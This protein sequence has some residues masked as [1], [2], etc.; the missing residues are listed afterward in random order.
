M[1]RS[2]AIGPDL[3]EEHR[4]RLLRRV[5][6]RFLLPTSRP[7][8][9]LCFAGGEL[10]AA[11]SLVSEVVFAPSAPLAGVCDLAVA[12]NPTPA[13]LRQAWSALVPGGALYTEWYPRGS[14]HPFAIGRRLQAAGFR[15]VTCYVP[16]RLPPR[17]DLWLPLGAP[18]ALRFFLRR[19]LPVRRLLRRL[20]S[21]AFRGVMVGGLRI[22]A[23]RP[24]C[25]VAVRPGGPHERVLP[26]ATDPWFFRTLD[27]R[28]PAWR[29]SPAP[30]QITWTLLTGGHRSL[31]KVVGLVLAE[32]NGRP[33]LVV[34]M[35]RV[36][37]ATA[38]LAREAAT[39]RALEALCP[40]GL[41]GVPRLLFSEDGVDGLVIGET[42]VTGTPIAAMLRP[43]NYHKVAHEVT[44]WLIDLAALGRPA[45]TRSPWGSI[46]EPALEEFERCFA[47][48]LDPDMVQETHKLLLGLGDLPVVCE[49]RDFAPWNV[50]RGPDG[51]LGALDW[52]SSELKGIPALDLLYM[53]AYLEFYLHD[54]L[55]S[56][57]CAE[58]YRDALDPSTFTGRVRRECVARYCAEIGIDP[59]L[60]LPLRVFVWILHSR[61]EYQRL[62]ADGGGAPP[63][64]A[65]RKGLFVRLWQMELQ[66]GSAGGRR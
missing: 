60:I 38:G 66:R 1:D 63:L 44:S 36:P 26:S 31:S 32:P 2:Q 15:G 11:L 28:L 30:R 27:T 61:S 50:L 51:R 17:C 57:R 39:L 24:T 12:I 29:P 53:L 5:D 18:G 7:G 22:G 54:A 46:V 25:A 52:E 42:P 41:P 48:I 10:A 34:K 65:L 19:P 23:S 4:N 62:V 58:S 49:H 64:D 13:Q 33:H 3:P 59:G 8:T 43:G 21:V 56:G 55:R 45:P 47:P 6:W 35:T 9:T 20:L 14:G 16:W 40:G 37:E